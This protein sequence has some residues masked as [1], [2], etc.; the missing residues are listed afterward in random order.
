VCYKLRFTLRYANPRAE[1][2]EPSIRSI[3]FVCRPGQ[4]CRGC[5]GNVLVIIIHQM[6]H[7]LWIP[8]KLCKR[9][10]LIALLFQSNIS[11]SSRADPS[12][13]SNSNRVESCEDHCSIEIFEFDSSK[14]FCSIEL[15]NFEFRAGKPC[16]MLDSIAISG[17]R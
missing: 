8:C 9:H 7:S 2:N 4:R 14:G 6:S 17:R 1:T 12:V 10:A 3:R 13:R 11:S 15:E 5:P 16:S